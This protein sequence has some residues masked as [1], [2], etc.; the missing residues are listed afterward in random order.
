MLWIGVYEN[1]LHTGVSNLRQAGR[2]FSRG[3]TQGESKNEKSWR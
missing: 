3:K 2:K 1:N